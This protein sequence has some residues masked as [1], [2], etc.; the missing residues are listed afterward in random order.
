MSGYIILNWFFLE[1]FSNISGP[2]PYKKDNRMHYL[3]T[4]SFWE[5]EMKIK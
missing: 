2:V 5:L 1:R 4:S 3:D